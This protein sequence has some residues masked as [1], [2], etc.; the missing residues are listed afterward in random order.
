MDARKRIGLVAHDAKKAELLDWARE[1]RERLAAHELWATGT[2]GGML[3]DALGLD[4][5]R[6]KSGP[7]GGDQ[8]MG[9]LIAEAVSYTHLTLPTKRIV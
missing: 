2:T 7:L 5:H 6:L 1:H 4:I 8:Q 9:A 3:A